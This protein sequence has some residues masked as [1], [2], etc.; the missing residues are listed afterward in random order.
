MA[1]NCTLRKKA[2][3]PGPARGRPAT[4]L[5]GRRSR[6]EARRVTSDFV[7]HYNARRL[8]SSL[9]YIAPGDKLAS[10]E[11]AIFA[12]RDRK[13]EAARELR[14][15]RRELARQLRYHDAARRTVTF[16]QVGLDAWT[17]HANAATW[18]L[19]HLD[20]SRPEEVALGGSHS[21]PPG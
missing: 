2:A 19:A 3:R 15:Q 21:T 13:L 18:R 6:D 14:R 11:T 12:E 10:R 4:V 1:R 9:G 5:C 16:L 7:E 8:H 17:A 20:A